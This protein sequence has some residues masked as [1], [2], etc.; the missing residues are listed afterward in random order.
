MKYQ[1]FLNEVKQ[2]DDAIARKVFKL[3]VE[4]QNTS[5]CY[6]CADLEFGYCYSDDEILKLA[7]SFY[8]AVGVDVFN[9]VDAPYTVF[10]SF[11][12]KHQCEHDYLLGEKKNGRADKYAVKYFNELHGALRHAHAAIDLILL[13][14][15]LYYVDVYSLRYEKRCCNANIRYLLK[16]KSERPLHA[17]EVEDLKTA[18]NELSLITALLKR[19]NG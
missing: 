8:N 14:K 7:K 4:L 9:K 16:C 12:E 6:I 3:F 13:L 5:I 1:E 15:R 11:I 18:R 2:P 19:S 17:F 10:S